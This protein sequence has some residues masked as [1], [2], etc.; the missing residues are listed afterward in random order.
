MDEEK[1]LLNGDKHMSLWQILRHS[2]RYIA[3]EKLAII[4][5]LLLIVINVGVD[6]VLPMMTS[7]YVV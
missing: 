2:K 6:I 4:L 5:S 7:R 3:K 1:E